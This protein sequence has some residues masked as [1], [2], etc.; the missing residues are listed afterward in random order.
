PLI[1]KAP[2]QKFAGQTVDAGVQSGD[3]APTILQL[4]SLPPNH[5]MQGRGLLSLMMKESPKAGFGCGASDYPLHHFGWSPVRF[6]RAEKF[7]YIEAPKPELYDHQLDPGETTNIIS[8]HQTIATE[9]RRQLFEAMGRW[10]GR[11][12]ASSSVQQVDVTT[13]EKLRSL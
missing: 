6:L 3:I 12:E 4:P 11:D 2:S 7:K 9:L 8:A 5:M 10:S 13:L 1:V